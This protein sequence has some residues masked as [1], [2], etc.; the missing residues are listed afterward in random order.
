MAPKFA[1]EDLESD[2]ELL[3]SMQLACFTLVEIWP[4]AS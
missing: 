3:N 4:T 1:V 2:R